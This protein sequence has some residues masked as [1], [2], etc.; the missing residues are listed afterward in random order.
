MK[1]NVESS[2]FIIPFPIYKVYLSDSKYFY[3]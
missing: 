2:E 3:K 1:N